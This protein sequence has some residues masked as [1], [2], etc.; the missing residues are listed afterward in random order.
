MTPPCGVG[1]SVGAAKIA[2]SNDLRIASGTIDFEP[3]LEWCEHYQ[4]EGIASKRLSSRYLSGPCR[5]WQKTKCNGW[6]VASQFRHKL[7]EG[8]RKQEPDPRVRE[9][10]KKHEELARVVASLREP[11]RSPGIVRE[12]KKHQAI[13]ERQIAELDGR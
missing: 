13:L 2:T 11:G 5:D 1:E 9:L 8:P 4:L 10:K 3:F 12:L 6:L 7:F